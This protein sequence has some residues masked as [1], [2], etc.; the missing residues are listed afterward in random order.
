MS[1]IQKKIL[2]KDGR[3]HY[4]PVTMFKGK[5]TSLGGFRLKGDAEAAL[6]RAEREIA[7]GTFGK[8]PPPPP[9]TLGEYYETWIASKHNLK[10]S[11]LKSYE[12][13]FR[14]HVLPTFGDMPL[15]EIKSDDVQRWVNDLA[16]SNLS[17]A[18]V[19]KCFRYFRACMK[20][21][22]ARDKIHKAPTMKI[23]LPRPGGEDDEMVFLEY[24]EITRLLDAAEEPE[25]TLW[26]VLAFSGLRLGEALALKWKSVNFETSR[27]QVTQTW[28]LG[29]LTPPKTK[30][31]KRRVPIMPVLEEVLAEH[32]ER[33]GKPGKEAFLF[34]FD[35]KQPLDPANVR[36]RFIETL[37]AAGL[38]H[39][40]QHSLRHSYASLMLSVGTSVVGL[41]RTLGHASATM[42]LN[43][44][45]HMM[46]GDMDKPVADASK[47]I[48]GIRELEH[49]PV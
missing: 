36:K 35:G 8:E 15:G 28:S 32:Y 42:T 4:Y 7:D 5:E 1:R 47:I 45:S 34:S 14:L 9:L 49:L 37:D 38:E 30:M 29:E 40:T 18:S 44:Y 2:K 11:T 10:A 41:Q 3:L 22:E 31:S 33:Q 48:E 12:H 16:E 27:I 24:P 6:K 26:S 46:K 20:E 21:A 17:P 39:V 23:N 19:G 13:T 43:V 25:K